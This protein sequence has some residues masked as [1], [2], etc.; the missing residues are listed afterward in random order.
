MNER[1]GNGD[2]ATLVAN[3]RGMSFQY[4]L[5]VGELPDE[6]EMVLLSDLA[7]AGKAREVAQVFHA[8]YR[9]PRLRFA[10]SL[11]FQRCAHRLVGIVVGTWLLTGNVPVLAPDETALRITHGGATELHVASWHTV[12]GSAAKCMHHVSTLM[13]PLV[14]AFRAGTGVGRANL[15]GNVAATVGGVVRNARRRHEHCGLHGAVG[16]DLLEHAIGNGRPLSTYGWFEDAQF[17]R[18]SCCHWHTTGN[19]NCDWCT[20]RSV[21]ERRARFAQNG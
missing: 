4:K 6:S 20:H 15:H 17:F 16:E 3:L 12:H 8:H 10:G 19:D 7:D 11:S 9:T 2:V 21:E 5:H 18:A 13:E 1:D 14:D